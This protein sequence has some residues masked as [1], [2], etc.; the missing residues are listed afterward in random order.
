[1]SGWHYGAANNEVLSHSHGPL[2][3]RSE[4]HRVV[5]GDEGVQGCQTAEEH[6]SY[7]GTAKLEDDVRLGGNKEGNQETDASA[8][9]QPPF[10]ALL[11]SSASAA[12][13]CI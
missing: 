11:S 4:E 9:F 1:M 2:S 10:T 12:E 7:H 8:T 13:K 3:Q 5:E 6:F